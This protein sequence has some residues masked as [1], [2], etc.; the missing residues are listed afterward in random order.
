ME[1]DKKLFTVNGKRHCQFCF[2][3]VVLILVLAF[4]RSS[5]ATMI[6]SW[7]VQSAPTS[8]SMLSGTTSGYLNTWM[9]VVNTPISV[10]D[11]LSGP[12]ILDAGIANLNNALFQL[13]FGSGSVLNNAGDDL[14]LFDSR[15]DAG[16]YAISSSY[17]DFSNVLS[18][19]SADFITTGES[20]EYYLE[21]VPYPPSPGN[22]YGVSIDL[23]LL[24]IPDGAEVTDFRVWSLN[25]MRSDFIGM[26]SLS[27]SASPAAHAPEPATMLLFGAGLAGLGVFRKKF[28]KA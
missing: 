1:T 13:T 2:L 21:N 12:N 25:G 16:S 28:K 7:D 23:A 11:A 5:S 24:G 6:G 27:P 15:Y 10:N 17:D 22:I 26:G 20:R 9:N 18:I 4:S 8:A 19:K 3:A 14:V